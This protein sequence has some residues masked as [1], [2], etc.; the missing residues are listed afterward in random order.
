MYLCKCVDYSV[1]DGAF[2]QYSFIHACLC[3]FACASVNVCDRCRLLCQ[4]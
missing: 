1:L 2:V 4:G 3:V